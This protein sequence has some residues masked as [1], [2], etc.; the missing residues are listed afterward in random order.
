MAQ[1]PAIYVIKGSVIPYPGVSRLTGGDV[2]VLGTIPLVASAVDPNLPVGDQTLHVDGVF[3]LPKDTS[4]FSAGDA[5]YWDDNGTPV[6]GT[7]L[8]GAATSTASGN[9]L[10]GLATIDA[11]TGDS[12]ARTL[13]SAAKRTTTIAGSVTADDITGSDSSLGIG[14]LAGN[15]SAGGAIVVTGGTAAA[16]AYNGGAVTISGGA[17]PAA[18][19]VGGALTL[20]SGSGDASNGTA[21]AVILDSNGTGA[22]KGSITIGTNAASV[23]F[24]KQPRMPQA[25][26]AA[27][28]GNIG[29]AG[30]LTAGTTLVSGS[31]N[32]KGVQLPSA[33][34]GVKCVVIN[35]NTDKTLKVYPPV[36][37]AIGAAGANNAVTVVANGIAVFECYDT[38]TYY[39]GLMAG[40]VS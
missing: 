2:V 26:V 10:I 20:L 7:A 8:S 23:S 12:Y 39:A 33:A 36:G 30:A 38:N 1:T 22:T 11:V 18:G 3:D 34:A 27:N 29:T 14:G 9:N 35:Q 5:V 37:K 16:G 13:L 4:T 24:G 21:G 25:T 31:D 6:T 17:G 32:S 15:A 19:N 28:G 40:I